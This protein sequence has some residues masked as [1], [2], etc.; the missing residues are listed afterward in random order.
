MSVPCW[1]ADVIALAWNGVLAL[2]WCALFADFSLGNLALGFSA[3]YVGLWFAWR[4][5]AG[6]SYFRKVPRLLRFLLFYAV[7]IVVAN[8]RVAYDVIT[9]RHRSRPAVVAV[10]LEAKTDAEIL[11][12]TNL[13]TLTPGSLTLDVS[14]DRKTVFVHAMF[15]DDVD[16][17]RRSIK[18]GLERRLLEVLR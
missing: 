9:P 15:V 14:Q 7:E 5:D 11:I 8:A 16:A 1:E 3:G 10:P 17:F 6:R 18:D 13:I 12:L 2:V 4:G